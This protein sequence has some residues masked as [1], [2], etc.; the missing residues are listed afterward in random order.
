MEDYI[1]FHYCDKSECRNYRGISL[2]SLCT[3]LLSNMMLFKLRDAVDKAIREEQCGFR[4]GKG[5]VDQFFT[6]RLII[7]KSL[8]CQTTLVLS[9]INYEQVYQTNT[10]K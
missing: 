10:L 9:F 5:C 6:L 7:E 8:R 1:I 3:K 2:L 4:K